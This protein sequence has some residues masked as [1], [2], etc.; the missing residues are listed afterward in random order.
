M[1]KPYKLND[2]GSG[3]DHA[4]ASDSSSLDS[5]GFKQL[6]ELAQQGSPDAMNELI[7]S[8]QGYLLLVANQELDSG[9]RAKVGA[10]DLVQSAL[11][12]AEQNLGQFQGD[13]RKT[14]LA[15]LRKILC[16]EINA[17]YRKYFQTEK[18]NIR[19]EMNPKTGSQIG[20]PIADHH[21]S[22]LTEAIIREETVL[23]REAI[24]RL[25]ND[26]RTVVVLRNWERLSFGQVGQ[27]MNRST[28]A[29]KKLWARAIRQLQKELNR[30]AERDLS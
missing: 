3:D 23:L 27:R 25:P 30:E 8:L 4:R 16:N 13:S 18:R 17:N 20:S 21:P 29:A 10:S 5:R 28:D 11:V 26:Y 12:Q 2:S 24:T 22:P 19:R 7:R 14:L 9:M 15:W 1:A 6:I